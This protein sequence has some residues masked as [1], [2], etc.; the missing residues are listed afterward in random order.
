MSSIV[1]TIKRMLGTINGSL[2]SDVIEDG[3]RVFDKSARIKKIK[4]SRRTSTRNL[5][6][7]SRVTESMTEEDFKK[8]EEIRPDIT[9][10][11]KFK[12]NIKMAGKDAM[13]LAKK[14]LQISSEQLRELKNKKYFNFMRNFEIKK[15]INLKRDFDAVSPFIDATNKLDRDQYVRLWYGPH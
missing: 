6:S 14:G 4:E 7:D 2:L 8:L 13:K 1:N 12:K 11:E 15:L 10:W 5:K 9:D 3:F